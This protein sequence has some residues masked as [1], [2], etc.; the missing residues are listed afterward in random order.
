MICDSITASSQVIRCLNW[1]TTF[2][3]YKCV[4]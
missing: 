1:V 3:K 4:L 2:I